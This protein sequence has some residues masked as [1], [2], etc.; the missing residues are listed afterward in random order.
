MSALILLIPGIIIM[1]LFN[2]RSYDRRGHRSSPETP[3]EEAVPP[4]A[5]RPCSGRMV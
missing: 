1:M 4:K 2:G 5:K 3:T